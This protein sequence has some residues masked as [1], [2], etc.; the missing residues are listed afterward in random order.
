VKTCWQIRQELLATANGSSRLAGW[1]LACA[2][3]TLPFD[4]ALMGARSCWEQCA[5]SPCCCAPIHITC[6]FC[7]IYLEH[8]REVAGL[9]QH[10]AALTAA[11][12][13]P[14][15]EL[16]PEGGTPIMEKVQ[17]NVPS[18]WA[19]H[20]TLKVREV[21]SQLPGVTDIVASSAFRVVAMS[22]DPALVTP[23][24]IM[25]ALDEAGYPIATAG[26]EVLTQPVPVQNGRRDPAW[27]RLGFRVAKTDPRDV[28]R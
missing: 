18:L 15:P 4:A 11:S 9:P 28:K 13:I 2:D 17:F 16:Q 22:Y 14:E 20:H 26:A 8:R 25:A 5:G 27:D 1:N 7:E 10:E 3:C 19:D 23:G 21:L 12:S 24:A 6:D